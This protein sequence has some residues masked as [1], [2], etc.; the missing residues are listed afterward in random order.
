M[1]NS[2]SDVDGDEFF[3][4]ACLDVIMS[5][6]NVGKELNLTRPVPLFLSLINIHNMK[7]S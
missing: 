3:S 1:G 6:I 7:C 4:F 2:V 5:Q